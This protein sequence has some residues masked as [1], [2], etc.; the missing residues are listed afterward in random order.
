[1]KN[2]F[3][4]SFIAFTLFCS[5]VND[6]FDDLAAVPEESIKLPEKFVTSLAMGNSNT[7]EPTINNPC[8]MEDL[9]KENSPA[10]KGYHKENYLI[11]LSNN[12]EE[13]ISECESYLNFI[14]QNFLVPEE[15]TSLNSQRIMELADKVDR[16]K[17]LLSV[18]DMDYRYN[19]EFYQYIEVLKKDVTAFKDYRLGN[20]GTTTHLNQLNKINNRLFKHLCLSIPSLSAP[21][22]QEEVKEFGVSEAAV[23]PS[24][25]LKFNTSSK[26]RF[27]RIYLIV[28]QYISFLKD[29][30]E[31]YD[32][33][34]DKL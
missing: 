5:C 18:L 6:S 10:I 32:K 21:E 7:G 11:Q 33:I 29:E 19:S 27:M 1:M 2:N 31:D 3:L 34:I 23:V 8:K 16:N 30:K 13:N 17:D 12:I 15:I 4:F 22:N 24:Y 20:N 26:K 25:I 28:N 9:K 14:K